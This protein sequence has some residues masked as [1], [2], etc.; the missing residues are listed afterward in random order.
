MLYAHNADVVVSGHVHNYERF[1][2]QNPDGVADPGRGIR[3]FVVGTGGR[4]LYGFGT[5][6]ANSEVRNGDTN[7]V[8]KL[9]LHPTSYD[10]EFVPVAGK[11]FT[12]SGSDTCH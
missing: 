4:S 10:W 6:E 9:T 2:P 12:D 7:G 3:A 5:A 1:G 11:T 8:I